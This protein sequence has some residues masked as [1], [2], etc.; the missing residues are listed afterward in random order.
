MQ[1]GF[2]WHLRRREV[3]GN[4]T[5]VWEFSTPKASLELYRKIP[6]ISPG[7]Y[8]FKGPFWGAYFWRGFYT[9]GL[10]FGILRYLSSPQRFNDAL[11]AVPLR[12]VSAGA[13]TERFAYHTI[14]AL[15]F[16]RALPFW[17]SSEERESMKHSWYIWKPSLFLPKKRAFFIVKSI[18]SLWFC[19]KNCVIFF[20]N[21]FF[22]AKSFSPQPWKM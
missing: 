14:F 13:K 3:W 11:L 5:R 18:W 6:K 20:R 2:V 16:T 17:A 10:I 4:E 7:A 12:K 15:A 9:E 8:F 21:H 22:P 19:P 1:R